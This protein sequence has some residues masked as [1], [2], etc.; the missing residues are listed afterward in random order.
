MQHI[1]IS[2]TKEGVTSY[3]L[4]EEG[5]KQAKEVCY[6]IPSVPHYNKVVIG[7]RFRYSDEKVQYITAHN[8]EFL[9]NHSP[10][11]LLL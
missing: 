2:N 9:N 3:G 10:Y 6:D 5:K 4:T 8:K 11:Q 7:L 1:L